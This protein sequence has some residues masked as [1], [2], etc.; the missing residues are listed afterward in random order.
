MHQSDIAHTV[1]HQVLQQGCELTVISAAD[2]QQCA[3]ALSCAAGSHHEPKEYL[4]MAHFLEHL[5]FRGS[6]NYALDD[7][8]MAF[9]QRHGGH[10]NAQTQAQQTLFHFQI[11]TPLFVQALA[12]LVDMLVAPRLS[13]EMLRSEREVIHEEFALYCAASQV[14]MDAAIAPCLLGEHPLQRF[15]AGHRDTLPIDEANFAAA[16][17]QFRHTA[18]MRSALK[19]VVVVPESWAQWQA[20]VL[21]ALQPLTAHPRDWQPPSLP[22]LQL[23]DQTLVQLNVPVATESL[24]V[25]IPVNIAGQGLAE[26]AE[27]TQHALAL[28]LPQTFF[29][30][31]QQLGCTQIKVRASYCAQ[32]QG[33]FTVQLDAPASQQAHLYAHLLQWLEQWR[34]QLY[35]PQQQVYEQ[36]AQRH[37]W[38]LA[39]PLQRAQRVL[40]YGHDPVDH[41]GVSEQCLAAMDAVLAAIAQGQIVQVQAGATAVA[42][43][44][45]QGLPLELECRSAAL[46]PVVLD[47]PPAWAWSIPSILVPSVAATSASISA[48][49]ATPTSTLEIASVQPHP[50]NMYSAAGLSQYQPVGLAPQL[51]V[52]YWGWALSDPQAVAQRLPAALATV[53]EVLRYNAVQWQTEC[54]VQT[55]FIRVIAPAAYL[56][57]ALH[58]ILTQLEQPL[59]AAACAPN[60]SFALR[61]LQQRLPQALAGALPQSAPRQE[62]AIDLASA[63]QY[64]LWLGDLAGIAQLPQ[65]ALQRLQPLPPTPL[66]AKVA[67]GWH[68]VHDSG[69]EDALLVIYI[70]LP[71]QSIPAQDRLRPL[72]RVIAQHLHSALQRTLRDEQGLCYA[73]FVLPYA[74]GDFEG[75]SCA[76]QS[77]QVSVAYLIQAIRQCLADFH[78]QLPQHRAALLAAVAEQAQLLASG[79]LSV[80]QLSTLAFRHWREQ[81]L[82]SGLQAEVQAQVELDDE[83]LDA[84]CQ[85]LQAHQQWCILSNQ[86]EPDSDLSLLL[87]R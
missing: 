6:Q 10:V 50:A 33:V 75:L 77:S 2:T 52:C 53:A 14:L 12:R 21:A 8:L 67:T 7:G 60:A 15:Y 76:V 11:Q 82:H 54:V 79:E 4:G 70:P 30:A 45:N 81:R 59:T 35:S 28:A 23:T 72:N 24:L 38:L 36:Q 51:A 26:L 71:A 16:L 3:V 64:A 80:E 41:P 47:E 48:R 49:A 32:M 13:P 61:R 73:V 63:A 20:L 83:Q 55:L 84:Y 25:H 29:S 62:P 44:Y 37:R 56:P 18:Y 27:V 74:Q 22:D 65:A 78:A 34:A 5:V 19:I 39:E 40:A 86:A 1:W 31:A 42:G 69:S 68:Q 17:A 85:A 9:I 57:V 66:K 87:A 58:L 46:S 43:R